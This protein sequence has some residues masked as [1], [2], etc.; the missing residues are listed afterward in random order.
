GG[1]IR[2]SVL[3]LTTLKNSEADFAIENLVTC[4]KFN[5]T[6]ATA[7]RVTP[8]HNSMHHS[9]W[10]LLF[11]KERMSSLLEILQCLTSNKKQE[12]ERGDVDG[13]RE[14]RIASRRSDGRG[15]HLGVV[16]LDRSEVRI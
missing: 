6:Q 4:G 1:Y 15:V 13:N 7:S 8:A 3:V 14:L 12:T 5:T 2:R 10:I 16:T 9:A 11:D